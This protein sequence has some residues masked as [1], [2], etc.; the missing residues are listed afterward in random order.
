VKQSAKTKSGLR[1]ETSTGEA[2]AAILHRQLAMIEQNEAGILAD[3]DRECLHDFRVAIRRGRA[4]LTQIP[5]VLARPVAARLKTD[6]ARLGQATNRLRDLDVHL[7]HREEYAQLLPPRLQ[8]GLIPLTRF[9]RRERKKEMKKIR[10]LLHGRTYRQT[11]E[12]LAQVLAA[13]T[14]EGPTAGA[15]AITP[16]ARPATDLIRQ[17]VAK[18]RRKGSKI[19][20]ATPDRKL[21]ALRI[22]LKKLR[23]LMEFFAPL[24][25]A[26]EIKTLIKQSKGLQENLG[27]FNDLSVQEETLGRYLQEHLPKERRAALTAAAVGGVIGGLHQRR[28]QVRRQFQQAF[29]D[30]NHPENLKIFGSEEESG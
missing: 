14:V 11:K 12:H 24:F 23:Y 15:R 19:T 9:L 16:V 17:A 22:Q 6:L 5:N 7:Q 27:E 13:F 25:P 21:H 29:A 1:P 4:C 18:V 30:F 26:R 10:A 3:Q 28:E 20:A 2:V 8:P